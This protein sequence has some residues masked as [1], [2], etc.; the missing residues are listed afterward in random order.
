MIFDSRQSRVEEDTE[1]IED[2][3]D[4]HAVAAYYAGTLLPTYSLT[5]TCE[6]GPVSSLI[7]VSLVCVILILNSC[8]LFFD[9]LL[10]CRGS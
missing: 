6:V 10:C 1:L 8:S 7:T 4:V 9:H 3:E 5:L 2:Q